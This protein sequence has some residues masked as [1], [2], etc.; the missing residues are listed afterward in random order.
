MN[1]KKISNATGYADAN[2]VAGENQETS[3]KISLKI[4]GVPNKIKKNSPIHK[5]F[6][7]INIYF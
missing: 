4:I 2:H 7:L 5:P 6:Y 1:L 3:Y